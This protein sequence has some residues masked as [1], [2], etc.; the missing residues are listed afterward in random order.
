MKSRDEH[1]EFQRSYFNRVVD[2]FRQP[3]PED[4][5]KRTREIVQVAGVNADD[6]ILD[7]GTGTGVLIQYMLE[8]GVPAESITGCDLSSEMLSEA[9]KRYPGV[10][11]IQSDIDKLPLEA[12]PFTKVFFNGCFGNM[13]DP[14]A[15][16]RH[17]SELLAPGGMV[18]LSHPLGNTF[19][20]GLQEREPELVLSLLPHESKLLEWSARI[21][22]NLVAIRDID[23]FYMAVLKTARE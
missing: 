17:T 22:L 11:F 3:L 9:A 23:Y 4:V 7:V 21:K 6:R 15:T 5:E 13:Y 16:L 8:F 19:L 2:F 14:V 12:G 10:K 20:Q 18:I 1:I